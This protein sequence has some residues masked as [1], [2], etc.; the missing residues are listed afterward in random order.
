MPDT[1]ATENGITFHSFKEAVVV[2]EKEMKVGDYLV[3]SIHD[4][5]RMQNEK[6][7]WELKTRAIQEEED[8]KAK[9]NK[10]AAK[11]NVTAIRSS[12][13]GAIL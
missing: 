6:V 10:K 1:V 7:K 13:T 2:K 3:S 5:N 11:A 4:I 9:K 8:R 12:D